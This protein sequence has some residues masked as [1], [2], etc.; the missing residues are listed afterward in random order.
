M[1]VQGT[2][3]KSTKGTRST[4]SMQDITLEQLLE[5]GAHF[6]H[7]VKRWNPKMGNYI[8]GA[9]EGVHIFDLAKTR[10]ALLE[11]AQALSKVAAEGGT[12]L[13]VGTK[14]QARDLVRDAAVKVN[15]PYVTLRWLGGTLTNFNQM[16]KSVDKLNSLK[17]MKGTSEW[18]TYTKREQ[19]L[20]EKEILNLERMFGGVLELKKLPEVIFVVDTHKEFT[21]VHEATRAGITI[22]GITDT[23]ADPTQV[24][25]PIPANDD[26]VKAVA[27]VLDVAVSAIEDGKKKFEQAIKKVESNEIATAA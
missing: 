12:V 16:R 5:A 26:A 21:A 19:M 8:Y 25:F 22:V 14:R 2:V 23:N 1:A 10:D 20:M 6:G 11:A 4:K 18:D 7:Q 3:F 13:F 27:L 15:M 9:R 17:K 24:D